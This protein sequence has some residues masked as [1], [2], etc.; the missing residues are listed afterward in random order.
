MMCTDPLQ[1]DGSCTFSF[2]QPVRRCVTATYG[3]ESAGV[4]LNPRQTPDPP[5]MPDHSFLLLKT[6]HVFQEDV[7]YPGS[8]SAGTAARSSGDAGDCA[9]VVPALLAGGYWS[10][11]GEL[12][13]G[14]G[15]AWLL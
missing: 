12:E 8:A 10:S 15:V 11:L 3:C 2:P 14:A 9:G 1:R 5:G 13:L 7:N 4:N 6:S